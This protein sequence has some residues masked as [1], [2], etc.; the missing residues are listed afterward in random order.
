[1]VLPYL[2]ACLFRRETGYST[3]TE[4]A[5]H[6]Q[7]SIIGVVSNGLNDPYTVKML[8]EVSRQLTVRG[9]I[10]QLLNVDA[11]DNP[12]ALIEVALRSGLTGLLYLTACT[13]E[14]AAMVTNALSALP[15]IHLSHGSV[16]N[17]VVINDYAAGIKVGELLLAQ[18]YQRFGYM[19]AQHASQTPLL[20]MKGF[21]TALEAADKTLDKVLIAGETDREPAYQAMTAYLRQARSSDRINALFCEN[22]LL[23]FGAM[24]AI[25]DF[26]QGV[27]IGVTGFNDVDEARLSTW[28]LTTWTQRCDL[29]VTEALNRLLDNRADESG[30]WRQG[31]LQIRH[32]HLAKQSHGEMSE[33]GCASRH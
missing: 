9:C 23:A 19:T 27:H 16:A 20:R 28:H 5:E 11:H 2:S 3:M 8:S 31:E 21:I 32:S 25:R 13:S 6:T 17:R 4:T 10:A 22:D 18:G 12:K 14:R 33:C 30:T 26:G 15:A 1:M 7:P 24:Q 29:L